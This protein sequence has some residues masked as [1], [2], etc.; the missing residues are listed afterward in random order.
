MSGSVSQITS[1]KHGQP[2]LLPKD[3][4]KNT[5]AMIKAL[6]LKG[7]PVTSI[8]IANDYT[9]LVRYGGYLNTK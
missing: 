4:M 3:L 2:A 8:L 5:I 9:I 7:V 6:Q 1:Q